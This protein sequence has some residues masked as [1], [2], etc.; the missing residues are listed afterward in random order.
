MCHPVDYETPVK[1]QVPPKISYHNPLTHSAPQSTSKQ[2]KSPEITVP[3]PERIP[4]NKGVD[5]YARS[6]AIV[7]K[8]GK[9]EC[10]R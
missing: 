8:T 1:Q 10:P 4:V 6:S 9:F 2:S 5:R 3:F 7:N